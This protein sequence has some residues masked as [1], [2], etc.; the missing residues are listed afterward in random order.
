MFSLFFFFLAIFLLALRLEHC[1]EGI[2]LFLSYS[3]KRA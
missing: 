2:F 1:Y 3:E